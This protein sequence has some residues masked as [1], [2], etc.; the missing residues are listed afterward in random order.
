MSAAAIANTFHTRLGEVD[1]G[2]EC[3]DRIK[4]FSLI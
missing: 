1:K 4:S 3:F 2:M